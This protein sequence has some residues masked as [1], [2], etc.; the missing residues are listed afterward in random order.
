[1]QHALSNFASPRSNRKHRNPQISETLN[2]RLAGY[3]LAAMAMS[4]GVPAA[5]Q[6][7][8]GHIVYTPANIP[9]VAPGGSTIPLDL[10][11]DGTVDFTITTTGSSS[12]RNGNFYKHVAVFE[13][14]GAGNSAIAKRA[15]AKGEIIDKGGQFRSS[16]VP[17]VALNFF[18]ASGHFGTSSK[19]A[20]KHVNDKYLGVKFLIGGQAHEGW[21]RLTMT[22]SFGDVK[23]TITGYAYDT[24]AN[25]TGLAAGQ[26]R[27]GN[28]DAVTGEAKPPAYTVKPATLRML[29]LGA[30]GLP[31]WR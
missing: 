13:T 18:A 1:M 12:T 11:N 25:E 16:Q 15:L 23:G 10:N 17:M 4:V 2:R 9:I 29:S 28:E 14:P 26:I 31:L 30:A 22:N 24:V 7:P 3:G 20:F 19:G 21:V 8:V 5:G 6:A 27:S